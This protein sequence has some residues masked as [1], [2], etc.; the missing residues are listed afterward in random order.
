VVPEVH[1]ELL[2][3]ADV[4]RNVVVL[5]P[6]C[7]LGHLVSVLRFVVIAY[8]ADNCGVCCLHT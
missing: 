1:D 8:Q 7:Q 2:G 3:V 5:A 4:Q 6:S